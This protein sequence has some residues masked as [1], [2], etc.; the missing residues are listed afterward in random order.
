MNPDLS[1]FTSSNFSSSNFISSNLIAS[2][3]VAAVICQLFPNAQL[4]NFY[5]SVTQFSC[6]FTLA[7]PIDHQAISLIEEAIRGLIKSDSPIKIV[8]MMNQNA[9][10]YLDHHG[11]SFAAEQVLEASSNTV[12]LIELAGFHGYLPMAERVN[13]PTSIQEVGVIKIVEL[14]C[15]PNFFQGLEQLSIVR[16]E[17]IRAQDNRDLKAKHKQ[18]K[19]A[20]EKDHRHQIQQLGLCLPM[21]MGTCWLPKGLALRDNLIKS[22]QNLIKVQGFKQLSMPPW[23]PCHQSSSLV[24]MEWQGKEYQPFSSRH[25][26]YTALFTTHHA[27]SAQPTRFAEIYE[28]WQPLPTSLERGLLNTSF[29]TTD[30]LY[31]FCRE[32]QVLKEL[33]SYLQFINEFIKI[34]G[35]ECQWILVTARGSRT[36][37]YA[38][39]HSDK[40]KDKDCITGTLKQWQQSTAWLTEAA[41]LCD[42]ELNFDA[43]QTAAK[44]PLL[45]CLLFDGYGQP[46]QGAFLGI[47]WREKD[48]QLRLYPGVI[49]IEGSLWGSLERLIAVLIEKCAGQIPFWPV[50]E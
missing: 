2:Q 41:K 31:T 20:K 48:R 13:L 25:S 29:Y 39:N 5:A 30:R 24:T 36:E 32:E 40:A 26:A 15:H 37:H 1:N 35:F 19:R 4:V 46:W 50:A 21:Q 10:A 18:F 43:N 34:V 28:K 8:E 9:A 44:G 49:A 45:S 11:Q 7:Y 38:T 27:T 6:D 17:G 22:W 42:L 47:D 16:F 14:T 3:V 23:Q 12:H 33:I